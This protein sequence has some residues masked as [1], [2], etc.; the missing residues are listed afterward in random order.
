MTWKYLREYNTLFSIGG[1]LKK[2][3]LKRFHDM[4]L[5]ITGQKIDQNSFKFAVCAKKWKY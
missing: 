1:E 4:L 5:F 3:F 2:P